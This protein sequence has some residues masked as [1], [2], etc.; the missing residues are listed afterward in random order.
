ARRAQRCLGTASGCISVA[1][2]TSSSAN[3]GKR[4]L[5]PPGPGE[6]SGRD[7]GTAE[8]VSKLPR[9]VRLTADKALIAT[10]RNEHKES[11]H[12]PNDFCEPARHR[13]RSVEEL[14]RG[15]W[16]RE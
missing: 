11:P 3:A 10:V 1:T 4:G 5:R 16:F 14:L 12:V 8:S 6:R 2:G 7:G 9:S 13:S 15:P